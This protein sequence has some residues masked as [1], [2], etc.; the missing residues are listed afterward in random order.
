MS[1]S[2]PQF[3][4]GDSYLEFVKCFKYLGHMITDT[5]GD[6]LNI[7]REIRNFTSTNILA[8]RL[9]CGRSIAEACLANSCHVTTSVLNFSLVLNDVVTRILFE[10]GLPSFNTII[11]NSSVIPSLSRHRSYNLII[12]HLN[13]IRTV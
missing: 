9:V 5:L 11:H 1:V 12:C 6:D 13:D 4:L 8:R 10:L 2:F 3:K 7:Q